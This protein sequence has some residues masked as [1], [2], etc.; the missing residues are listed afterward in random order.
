MSFI[1]DKICQSIFFHLA[2]RLDD[3][4]NL[5]GHGISKGD[6]VGGV[7]CYPEFSQLQ[8]QFVDIVGLR[9]WNLV[10]LSNFGHSHLD[11]GLVNY[12]AV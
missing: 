12:Q 7:Q 8:L 4:L 2:F 1:A 9:P 6:K 11:V 10:F 3:H 5:F